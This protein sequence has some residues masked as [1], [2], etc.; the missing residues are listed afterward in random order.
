VPQDAFL[1]RGTI[2]ENIAHTR[3]EA[4]LSEVVEAATLAGAHEFISAQPQGYD[5]VLQE[6]ASNLSGG[7]RQRLAIARALLQNP[8]MLILDEATSALDNESERFFLQNL[9][10]RF[11]DRTV[12]LIAHRLSTVRNADLIVV[13]DHG[14]IVEAGNHQQLVARRGLYYF[15]STQQLDL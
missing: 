12:F 9:D 15:L 11:Q 2:R 3:P 7:E 10:T 4:S 13:L 14:N 1:F 6:Q 5:T 8:R